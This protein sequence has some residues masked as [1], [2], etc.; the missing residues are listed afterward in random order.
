MAQATPRKHLSPEIFDNLWRGLQE[1]ALWGSWVVAL[2]LLVALFSYS[3]S[4]PGWTYSAEPGPVS[5]AGGVVGAFAANILFNLFGWFA[6]LVPLLLGYGGWLVYRERQAREE[7]RERPSRIL[8]LVRAVGL[9][10]VVLSTTALLT[11]HMLPEPDAGFSPGGILGE[12]FHGMLVAWFNRFGASLLLLGLLVSGITLL[13]GLSWFWV[14][15]AVG[16]VTLNLYD[17][18]RQRLQRYL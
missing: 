10:L 16:A 14:M 6:Y 17:W 4:D 3:P 1:V 2:F 11:T 15:D 12:S 7:D 18:L 5:N 8:L 9:L 13:T